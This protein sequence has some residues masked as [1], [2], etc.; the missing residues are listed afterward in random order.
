MIHF[1]H[2]RRLIENTATL[3]GAQAVS[4]LVPLLTVP[5]LART[6]RPAGWASV[7]IAQAIGNWLIL[8]IEYGFDLSGTRAVARA[9]AAPDSLSEVIGGVQGAKLLLV[10]VAAVIVAILFLELPALRGDARLLGWTLAFAAFRGLNPFWYFQGVERVRT[11]VS[12]DSTSKAAAALGV[13]VFVHA[14]VDGWKVIAL[15]AVAAALSL[16]I[17]TWRMSRQVRMIPPRFH[18]AWS[19][20]RHGAGVFGLRAASGLSVQ[21][22]TIILA[23]LSDPITVSLFGG[24]ERV[25]RASINLFQPLTQAFLPRLSFLSVTDPDHG[26]RTVER[27]LVLI[28]ALGAVF[29]LVAFAGAPPLTHVLLGPGYEGAIP[30]MRIIAVLPFLVAVNTVLGLYWAIPFGHE[31]AFLIAVVAGGATNIALALMLVPRWGAVGMGAAVVVAE[32]TV[33]ASLSSLFYL[34]HH[35][36]LSPSS[37]VTS[38]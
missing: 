34:R 15:Q 30:V 2:R 4:L 21:A 31:R 35:R 13:F 26:R 9:R 6:L 27:C 11:A 23:A 16:V 3:F 14:P 28:G 37:V 24:A 25:V 18:H 29:G 22:N 10:P 19:M 8:L 33:T 1:P 5:Y 36:R 7:L 38:P 20:L 12:V 17:L 32:L